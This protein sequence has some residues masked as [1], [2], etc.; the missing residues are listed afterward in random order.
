MAAH[1]GWLCFVVGSKMSNIFLSSFPHLSISLFLS[2]DITSFFTFPFLLYFISLP[3]PLLSLHPLYLLSCFYRF[4]LLIFSPPLLYLIFSLSLLFFTLP[5][6]STFHLF[7]D[8][9]FIFPSLY[10]SFPLLPLSFL[11]SLPFYLLP[12]FSLLFPFLSS[13]P[14][15]LS[16]S[17]LSRLFFPLLSSSVLFLSLLSSFPSLSPFSISSNAN[18]TSA[19]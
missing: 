1:S 11:S 19:G 7:R 13:H 4:S 3:P 12:S 9:F 2:H 6:L 5:L 10:L 16:L 14:L 15:S 17:S 8:I 18:P